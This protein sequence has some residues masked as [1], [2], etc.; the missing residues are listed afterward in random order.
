MHTRRFS[1]AAPGVACLM[2]FF[3]LPSV[4][5]ADVAGEQ[6]YRQR[7]ASCHGKAGEGTKK[8]PDPLVGD[9]SV[10]QLADFIA[11]T[12]PKGAKEKCSREDAATVAAY[13]HDAFYSP[14]AQARNK[15]PRVELSRLTVRQYRLAVADVI[16]SFRAATKPDERHGLRGEYFKARRF[17]NN[18]RIIDRI[19]PEVRF[20]FGT[21]APGPDKFEAAQFSIRWEGSVVAPDTGE[22]EFIVRTEHAARLFVNDT[23]RPLIDAWVKSGT[24]TEYRA[25]VFLLGGRAYPLRLEFSKSKQGVDDSKTKKKVPEVKASAALAWKPPHRAVEIIPSR[26][27]T[28]ARFAPTFVVTTPFPPDDRSVGYER[29]TTVSRAWDQA[30][31]DAAFEVAGYIAPRL[32]EFIGAKPEAPDAAKRA[33]DFSLRFAELAFRRP[34]ND[35]QKKLFIERQFAATSDVE[36]AVK[37]VVLLV[38]KSPR[39]LYREAEQVA[40]AYDTASRLSFALWDSLPDKELLDAAGAGR[41]ATREQIIAQ[42]ERMARDPRARAKLR[43]FTLQWLKVDHYPDLA[44]DTKQFPGFTPELASDLRTSLE[45]FLDEVLNSDSADFRQLLLGDQ[46]YMNSPLATYYGVD[47]PADSSFQKV[48]PKVGVRA[49]VLTQPYILAAFAYTNASSPIHRGVLLSRSILGLGLKPPPDAFTPLSPDLHPNL[50][51]RERVTLQTKSQACLTCHGMINPL[52][53]TLE[54]FDAV[55]R[56]RDEE[57]GKKIDTTGSY[58]TRAGKEIKFGGVRDLATFLA[59]SEEVHEAF[60][61]HL[62]HYMVKQP[63]VAYGPGTVPALRKRFAEQQFNVR[64]LMVAIAVETAHT[65]KPAG[66]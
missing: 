8:A 26:Y 13:I 48:Q 27:L 23:Q 59:D 44:K 65:R 22:Y 49:G 21:K 20:D 29:G 58:Q 11:K 18:E 3:L 25:S 5:A 7:C 63:A 64:K 6:I 16:G 62:F 41:L 51:T 37:R 15:P 32:Q 35:E 42:A 34:L 33:R 55:G 66:K 39:F 60:V 40:D 2:V 19:D 38:L 54:N 53:F 30:T 28:P 10:P 57:K 61:Q 50:T 46:L 47:L 36:L 43:E 17:Q 31:T 12:M 14:A 56:F 24:D 9:R 52:G 45:L 1:L 4:A